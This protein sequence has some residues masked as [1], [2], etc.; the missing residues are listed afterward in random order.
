MRILILGTLPLAILAGCSHNPPAESE[1]ES[2][3]QK[4]SYAAGMLLGDSLGNTLSKSRLNE[5][6]VIEALRD[7]L[8]GNE[9]RLSE[10]D[11]RA[12]SSA[13]QQEVTQRLEK[14]KQQAIARNEEQGQAFL[15]KNK[16]RADVKTLPSGVRGA[17]SL[18]RRRQPRCKRR[19][20][21]A[22]RW[23]TAGWLLRG[24]QS[25]PW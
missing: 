20:P 11:A 22:L 19:G 24:K 2:T 9:L 10:E 23:H 15:E 25:G 18:Q 14:E 13:Y 3:Q 7:K 17:E 12:A 6:L 16:K 21:R 1:L 8:K 5:D 4:A